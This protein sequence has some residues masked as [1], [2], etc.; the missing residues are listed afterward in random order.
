MT[1][2]ESDRTDDGEDDDTSDADES[3]GPASAYGSEIA[4]TVAVERLRHDA[5]RRDDT[6]RRIARRDRRHP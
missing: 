3:G 2:D 1:R 5:H 4:A 6:E